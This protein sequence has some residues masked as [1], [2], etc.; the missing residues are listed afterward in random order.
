MFVLCNDPI[1]YPK[2]NVEA[3]LSV[4]I[5]SWTGLSFHDDPTCIINIGD[6]PFICHKSFVFYREVWVTGAK[7]IIKNVQELNY[8]PMGQLDCAVLQRIL[9]GFEVSRRLSCSAKHF[10][11]FLKRQGKF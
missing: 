9:D 8:E 5:T 1:L 4:N 3:I 6:H 7:T 2:L 10:Y 11:N